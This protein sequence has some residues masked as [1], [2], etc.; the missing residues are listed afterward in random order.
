MYNLDA[1]GTELGG[2]VISDID[3]GQQHQGAVR[4]LA[5]HA[6]SKRIV[7]GGQDE[8]VRCWDVE[9]R[10]YSGPKQL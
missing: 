1:G 4:A 3:N 8:T 10:R 5:W 6:D 2:G 9:H 7:S